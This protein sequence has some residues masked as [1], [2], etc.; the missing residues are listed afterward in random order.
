M[1]VFW[2]FFVCFVFASFIMLFRVQAAFAVVEASKLAGELCIISI[3]VLPQP[4][5]P[6]TD[7]QSACVFAVQI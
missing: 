3:N 5:P 4:V 6:Q 1:V 2:G 7:M